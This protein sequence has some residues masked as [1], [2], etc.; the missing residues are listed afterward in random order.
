MNNDRSD[1]EPDAEPYDRLYA[2]VAF[3]MT[4]IRVVD[5]RDVRPFIRVSVVLLISHDK[6]FRLITRF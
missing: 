5:E 3:F 2:N 4:N 1:R 6:T